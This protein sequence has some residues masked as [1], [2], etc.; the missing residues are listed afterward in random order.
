[1]VYRVQVLFGAE[2]VDA[3]RAWWRTAALSCLSLGAIACAPHTA[4]VHRT[5]LPELVRTF[6]DE[7]AATVQ[8]EGKPAALETRHAPVLEV[9]RKDREQTTSALLADVDVQG[10]ALLFP[11]GDSGAVQE[12][13]QLRDVLGARLDLGDY[14]PPG[15]RLIWGVGL[16]GGGPGLLVAPFAEVR[17]ARWI[18]IEAG[19]LGGPSAAWGFAGA[20]LAPFAIGSFR[21]YVGG[22]AQ[23]IIGWDSDA[24]A[25]DDPSI[26][27]DDSTTITAGGARLGLE[28]DLLGGHAAVRAEFDLIHPISDRY[29]FDLTDDWIPFGGISATYFP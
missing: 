13:V 12:R 28:L 11:V 16:S 3:G 20:R 7:G 21:P 8:H 6:K 18:S 26:G 19:G 4:T 24:D 10:G 9:K 25:S 5:E 15:E 1:M 23:I 17:P 27:E 22:F 14:H 2:G 29:A